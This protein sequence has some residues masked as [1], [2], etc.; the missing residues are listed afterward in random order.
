MEKTIELFKVRPGEVF[1]LD[2]VEFVKLDED[3]G[4]TLVVTRD[5]VGD[6]V[7]FEDDGAGRDNHNNYVDSNLENVC[8]QWLKE[9]HPD[10]YMKI[11]VHFID[12]TTMDGMADYAAPGVAVRALTIDEY[13]RY[14]HFIP[15]TSKD[16]WLATGYTT[17]SSPIEDT[18]EVYNIGKEGCV[19]CE[20]VYEKVTPRPALYLRSDTLV[21]V[22]DG[23][24][25]SPL[26]NYTDMELLAELQRRVQK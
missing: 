25:G 3:S 4:A 18:T 1:T 21:S 20:S 6:D 16:Y 26:D 22:E 10:I 23:E 14:R 7:Q 9:E 12:L 13:R 15:L 2:G 24:E 17:A 19:F 11:V 8:E 5:V